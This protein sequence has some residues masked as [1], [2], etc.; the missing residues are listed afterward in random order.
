MSKLIT[1]KVPVYICGILLALC[2]ALFGPVIISTSLNKIQTYQ[3]AEKFFQAITA[4]DLDQAF[5]NVAYFDKSADLEPQITYEEAKQ[6]WVNRVESLTKAGTFIQSFSDLKTWTDDTYPMGEVHLT[7]MEN[8]LVRS[9]V[10][11]IHFFKQRNHWKVQ[12]IDIGDI[13]EKLLTKV[14]YGYVGK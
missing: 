8:G 9:Y 3:A 1:K 5:E 6:I 13:E 2:V 10:A 12:N 4:G 7:V 11:R 14:L